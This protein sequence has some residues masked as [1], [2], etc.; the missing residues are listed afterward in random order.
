MEIKINWLYIGIAI[1]VAYFLFF[2]KSGKKEGFETN[3][4]VTLK[5]SD[6]RY[7]RVCSDKQVCITSNES[8][9]DKFSIM[10][11]GDDLLSLA[12]G[13]YYIA[14]CF[15]DTCKDELI[16]ANNFNPYAPNA[17]ISLEKDGD[18]F[19]AKFYDDKYMSVDA[20][21]NIVKGS[22]KLKALRIQ[23]I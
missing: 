12:K 14:S 22:D 9:A 18:Y 19:Y 17:K 15:G 20:S 8:D 11:F 2:S 1:V 21:G 5:T 13:G 6:N 23:L 4:Q 10:K 7:I 16:K 3:Q